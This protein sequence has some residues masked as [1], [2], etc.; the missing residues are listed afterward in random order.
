VLVINSAAHIIA[1]MA[2]DRT[3]VGVFPDILY[4]RTYFEGVFCFLSFD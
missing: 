3:W 1:K 4:K 2:V